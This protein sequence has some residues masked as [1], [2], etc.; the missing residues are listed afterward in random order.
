MPGL[1][2]GLA[3]LAQ[4]YQHLQD[5]D[6]NKRDMAQMYLLQNPD[7]YQKLVDSHMADN[8]GVLQ[9]A[10]GQNARWGG[11][12]NASTNLANAISSSPLS[13]Q[14]Q[15][16]RQND[17]DNTSLGDISNVG[18]KLPQMRAFNGQSTNQ[19]KDQ[20]ASLTDSMVSKGKKSSLSDNQ[21]ELLAKAQG[22]EGPAAQH[23]RELENL[24]RIAQTSNAEASTKE[25]NARTGDLTAQTTQRNIQLQRD[26]D[27]SDRV[28]DYLK[29][30][31]QQKTKSLYDL[32]N[33]KN[34]PADV[35]NALFVSPD[36]SESLKSQVAQRSEKAR[37]KIEQ[38]RLQFDKDQAGKWHEKLLEG[39]AIESMA[40][41]GGDKKGYM[42]LFAGQQTPGAQ[43]AASYLQGAS[44]R[45]KDMLTNE[46]SGR[47]LEL[48]RLQKTMPQDEVQA[49]VD[50]LNVQ[51]ARLR[52]MGVNV[53]QLKYDVQ[54]S[55][56]GLGQRITE[57]LGAVPNKTIQSEKKSIQTQSGDK[58][59]PPVYDPNQ[60]QA[61]LKKKADL[62]DQIKAANPSMSQ[63]IIMKLVEA[64]MKD[65]T[66]GKDPT[67]PIR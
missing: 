49:A 12:S 9:Q 61:N 7:A 40:K 66:K 32:V 42:E 19:L 16:T 47:L 15:A 52:A 13:P 18:V 46:Y 31:P 11:N 50:A 2:Q 3:G 37:I 1:I 58:P 34:T 45:D 21:K 33:D 30:F 53:D 48:N 17:V 64:R 4:L 27:A 56:R 35:V 25:A 14:E 63:D 6:K 28:K 54:Q 60:D 55:G 10:L 65:S 8:P 39:T 41:F 67:K 20:T 26:K 29:T 43:Q 44:P 5:P 23:T 62:Y 51:G 57:G 36:T 22:V 38:D 59:K 24:E